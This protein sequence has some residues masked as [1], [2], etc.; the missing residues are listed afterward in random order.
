MQFDRELALMQLAFKY[1]DTDTLRRSL[2]KAEGSVPESTQT[3]VVFAA[4]QRAELALPF[5]R[6]LVHSPR[7][8]PH[9]THQAAR[10]EHRL[11]AAQQAQGLHGD[12][13][14]D[15]ARL[16]PRRQELPRSAPKPLR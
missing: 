5:A 8:R 10:A 3:C 6:Y 15:G 12:L 1:S 14:D 16:R 4:C 13:R 2:E 9:P 11:G 7:P